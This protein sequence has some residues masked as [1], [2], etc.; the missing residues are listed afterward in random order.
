MGTKGKIIFSGVVRICEIDI[1]AEKPE[2]L[3]IFIEIKLY[4]MFVSFHQ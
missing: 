4:Q 3:Y 1:E 2:I